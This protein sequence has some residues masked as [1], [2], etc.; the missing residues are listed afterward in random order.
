VGRDTLGVRAKDAA[1][2]L[3]ATS[4]LSAS[5]AACG[6]SAG[7]LQPGQSWQAAYDAAAPGAVLTVAAGNHGRPSLVGTKQVTFR[8]EEGTVVL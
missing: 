6:P 3:S 8:G 7:T 5:T 2:N 1:G 4:T